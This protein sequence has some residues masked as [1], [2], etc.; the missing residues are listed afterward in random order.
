MASWTYFHG[1]A[2]LSNN[3][4]WMYG[5]Q[6]WET[7]K[8]WRVV[9]SIGLARCYIGRTRHD[10]SSFRLWVSI[11]GVRQSVPAASWKREVSASRAHKPRRSRNTDQ[12]KEFP[13]VPC[14]LPHRVESTPWVPVVSRLESECR[15]NA[16]E[17]GSERV[18]E[19]IQE[20]ASAKVF[21]GVVIL[22][23]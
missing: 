12:R 4:R 21:P 19:R 17:D 10:V 14:E 1:Y 18:H 23:E 8:A 15:R 16:I 3:T 11:E 5:N 13:L 20:A 6:E 22:S 2:W 7:S 9:L